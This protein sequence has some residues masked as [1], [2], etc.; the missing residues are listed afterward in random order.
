MKDEI[1]INDQIFCAVRVAVEQVSYSKDYITR[2]AREQKIR[3]VHIGRNWYVDVDALQRYEEVQA[4][5]TSVR[6]RQLQQQRKIEHDLRSA[7]NNSSAGRFAT[8]ARFVLYTVTAVCLVVVL[9]FA[10]GAGLSQVSM[11]AAAPSAERPTAVV[12]TTNDQAVLVPE[13]TAPQASVTVVEDREIV[14]PATKTDWL[15]IRY[16]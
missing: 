16:E 13:F 3:A 6:N 12:S 7:M 11:L 10:V 1:Y 9:G 8:Q 4:L 5:E 15:R 14:K 2:L